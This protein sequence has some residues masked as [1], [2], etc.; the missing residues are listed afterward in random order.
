VNK[1]QSLIEE[2]KKLVIFSHKLSDW[3]VKNLRN[4]VFT[5]LDNVKSVEIEY[6]VEARE[7]SFITYKVTRIPRKKLGKTDEMDKRLKFLEQW[8]KSL[9]WNELSVSVY[10][11]KN[12]LFPAK[13]KK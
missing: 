2:M 8:T 10:D 6:D 3:H 9:F 12:K 11:G 13:V 1:Q 4:F 7:Q 5:T